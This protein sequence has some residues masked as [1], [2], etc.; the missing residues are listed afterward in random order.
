[1]NKHKQTQTDKHT[2][3]HKQTSKQTNTSKLTQTNKFKQTHAN[4]H[5][6]TNISKQ[7]H[8]KLTPART[9]T[10]KYTIT[11]SNTPQTNT[12]KHVHSKYYINDDQTMTR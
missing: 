5:T 12:G 7:T 11:H 3:E 4:K 9:H 10:Y 2:H 1:M 6:Q 8:K